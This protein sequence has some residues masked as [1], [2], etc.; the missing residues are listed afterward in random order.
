R[1]ITNKD[2]IGISFYLQI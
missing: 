1:I 2:V